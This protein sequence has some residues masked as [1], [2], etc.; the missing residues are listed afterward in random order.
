MRRGAPAHVPD[1]CGNHVAR[2]VAGIRARAEQRVVFVVVFTASFVI[3]SFCRLMQN[4]VATK[5]ASEIAEARFRSNPG[6]EES[7]AKG[8]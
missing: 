7:F 6:L 5:T 2:H 8:T 4:E 1:G 3:S